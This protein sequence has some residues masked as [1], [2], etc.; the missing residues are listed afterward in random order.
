MKSDQLKNTIDSSTYA[1]LRELVLNHT[2]QQIPQAI[3]PFTDVELAGSE[4]DLEVGLRLLSSGKMGCLIVAG[5][6]GTRL[7]FDGPKGVF[8][9]TILKQKSLFQLVAERTLAASN[10]SGCPLPLAI[11]TSPLNHEA[12]VAFFKQHSYFGLPVE[13]I[14]FF[15]QDM[16][17]MLDV[18]GDPL[19]DYTG[20]LAEGPTGN[21]VALERF[22][23]SGI[24]D[25]WQK[26]GVKYLNFILIDNALADPFDAELLGCHVRKNNQVTIKCTTRRDAAESV[27]LIVSNDQYVSVMEYSEVPD[28]ERFKLNPDGSFVHRCANL[29]LFCFS[30]DFV[31]EASKQPLPWHLAKKSVKVSN[32]EKLFAWKFEKFIF[33]LL[34]LAKRV[35]ALQYPRDDCF[36]PLKNLSGPDSLVTLQAQLLEQDRKR[37]SAIWQ[38]QAP[39]NPIELVPQC[40]YPTKTLLDR[41]RKKVP[42]DAYIEVEV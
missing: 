18:N 13:Q 8:P 9:V 10:R 35:S 23:S 33:D 19:L 30:M 39:R 25:A 16:R 41:W 34:P 27:G 6:Q 31:E 4:L 3:K 24:W 5:G 22:I 15:S 32:E 37:Y 17:P 2:E 7:G 12:T 38:R 21:G 29:S 42:T 1:E 20:R 28:S 26:N 11:M 36:A 40:Y 14:T